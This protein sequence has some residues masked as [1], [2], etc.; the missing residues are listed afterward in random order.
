MTKK[1][2]VQ[3]EPSADAA[4]DR[5]DLRADPTWVARVERQARRLGL[6][7]SAYIR[8]AT[9]RQLEIDEANAPAEGNH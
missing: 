7:V 6:N 5:V 9:T 8:L 4:R 2:K 1:K 3:G